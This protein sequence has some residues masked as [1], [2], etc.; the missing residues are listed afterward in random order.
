[1]ANGTHD[2]TCPAKSM[3]SFY[4]ALVNVAGPPAAQLIIEPGRGHFPNFNYT[5]LKAPAI[6]LPREPLALVSWY[7]AATTLRAGPGW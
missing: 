3:P 1:M 4:R 6:K 5:E 2:C 7:S